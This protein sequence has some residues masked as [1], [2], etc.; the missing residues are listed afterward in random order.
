MGMSADSSVVYV[1]ATDGKLYSISTTAGSMQSTQT[2]N[3]LL[4]YDMAAAPV[5]EDK[6]V[7]YV[8][9]NSG[10]VTAVDISAAKLL[11]K[12]KISNSLVTSVIPFAKDRLIVS[13]VDGKIACLQF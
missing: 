9:S 2:I 7:V 5:I 4:G 3:L 12:Y 6:G 11:W 1:K 13:T 8:P 10:V